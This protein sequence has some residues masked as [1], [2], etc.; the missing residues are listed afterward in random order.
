MTIQIHFLIIRFNFSVKG[1]CIYVI[2]FVLYEHSNSRPHVKT[3]ISGIQIRTYS[4]RIP[5][6]F[7]QI[8]VQ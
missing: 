3:S 7:I 8:R 2:Q 6:K 5:N 1:I 4:I